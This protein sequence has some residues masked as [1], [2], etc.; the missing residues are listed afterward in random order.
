MPAGPDSFSPEPE[1]P[2]PD[3]PGIK[4]G[5]LGVKEAEEE[6]SESKGLD[7]LG[8]H[9]EAEF[10]KWKEENDLEEGEDVIE[11]FLADMEQREGQ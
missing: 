5:E 11:S 10:R 4:E 2:K 7:I 9:T 1:K 8:G 3:Y 6:I